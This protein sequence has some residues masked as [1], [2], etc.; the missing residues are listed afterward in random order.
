MIRRI[1]ILGLF[2][3][4][5]ALLLIN[6]DSI[7]FSEAGLDVKTE[8]FQKISNTEGNS[9]GTLDDSDFFGYSIANLGDL[10]GDGVIDLVIGGPLDDDAGKARGAVWILF[11]E[12]NNQELIR[13]CGTSEILKD[14]VCVNEEKEIPEWIRNIFA[15]YS[16]KKISEDELINAIQFLIDEGILKTKN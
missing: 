11:S 14:G 7:Q 5:S 8:S 4:F 12:S 13:K 16:E 10:N 2:L 1:L 15:F 3:I 6:A 9:G